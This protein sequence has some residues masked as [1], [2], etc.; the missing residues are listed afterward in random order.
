MLLHLP[1]QFHSSPAVSAYKKS[2]S[3]HI[4][5]FKFFYT[6]FLHKSSHIP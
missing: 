6:T 4:C 5:S 1:T 2:F 3:L